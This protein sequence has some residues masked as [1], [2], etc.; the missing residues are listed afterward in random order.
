MMMMWLS[1]GTKRAAV[2]LR[3]K[4]LRQSF[5]SLL[6]AAKYCRDCLVNTSVD[7]P[8]YTRGNFCPH[9]PILARR[10]TMQLRLL[11]A[12]EQLQC[13]A[14]LLVQCTLQRQSVAMRL[15]HRNK[16]RCGLVH[17]SVS[18]KT[19]RFIADA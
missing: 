12:E 6:H 1:R 8:P 13:R 10:V 14:H 5:F 18:I 19:S 17:C 3:D 16:H 7:V 4:L 9:D 15:S 11:V 2:G